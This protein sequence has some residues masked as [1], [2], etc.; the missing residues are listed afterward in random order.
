MS[1][2]APSDLVVEVG[3]TNRRGHFQKRKNLMVPKNGDLTFTIHVDAREV[4]LGQT[5][6]ATIWFQNRNSGEVLH[7]PVTIV[8]N[9]ASVT[10][11]KTCDPDTVFQW[12]RVTCEI[13]MSNG[14]FTEAEVWMTDEM[15]RQLHL[16][17]SSVVGGTT[18][19]QTVE[20]HGS[21][22]AASPPSPDVAVDPLA[23]PFGYVPLSLFG[24]TPI[25]GVSDESISNFGVPAFDY[26]G[27]LYTS[28]GMV[29]NGYSVVGG[30][31]GADID[32]VN[33]DLPDPAVPNNVLA[34]FWTDLNPSFGGDMR[35]AVLSSGGN[36]W[37][38]LDWEGVLSYGDLLP[39]DFQIWI[40]INGVED[41]SFVYGPAISAGDGGFLTVGAENKFGNEGGT[42][43]FDGVGTPP[44]PSF[45]NGTYEVDVFS[46][47]GAPGGSAT[48]SFQAKGDH[49]GEWWNYAE[50]TSDVIAGTAIDGF[51]GENVKRGREVEADLSAANEVPPAA[52]TGTGHAMLGIRANQGTVCFNIDVAD[53]EGNV[54][55]AHI[56]DGE[57]GVNG[58]VVVNLDIP[59]NGLDGCVGGID[60]NLLKDI[61][62]ANGDYYVNVHTDAFPGGEVRGQIVD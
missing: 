41:I 5:R 49:P 29:S 40:G 54:V 2:D 62:K 32:F 7:F 31:T 9:E 50:V 14:A 46:V 39:N 59:G 1:V 26:A 28:I 15:P 25:G 60:T 37:I 36:S 53:L 22:F 11:D 47:P 18:K 58:P 42:V 24:V 10:V 38:V 4:P 6:M 51:R 34:P 21:L 3:L 57:A 61:R 12:D 20:F 48:V 56:H 19:G 45:P 27:E 52:S 55:A 16:V 17:K 23:S 33:T 35:I 44:A 30:G 43:Y 8:R 13:T